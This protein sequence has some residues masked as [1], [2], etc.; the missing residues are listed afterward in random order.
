MTR[1]D[2]LRT[3]FSN[4]TLAAREPHHESEQMARWETE[5]GAL[6]HSAG[7]LPTREPHHES[8]Q[9]ARWEAEGGALGHS[10]S[11]RPRP[12]P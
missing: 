5:G 4:T 1:H 10:A 6:G 9:M 12:L 11:R 3:P 8:E 2:K 7:R